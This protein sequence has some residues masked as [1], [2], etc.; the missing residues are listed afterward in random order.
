[1]G[2]LYE[3]KSASQ[4]KQSHTVGLLLHTIICC[5]SHLLLSKMHVFLYKDKHLCLVTTKSISLFIQDMRHRAEQ[6]LT[7]CACAWCTKV[8]ACHLYQLWKTQVIISPI[9]E[10]S[11]TSGNGGLCQENIKLL[12]YRGTWPLWAIL[13]QNLLEHIMQGGS[14]SAGSLPLAL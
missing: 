9:A 10:C 13:L 8:F 5:I 4:E 6:P 2:H 12:G 14:C 1:M 7:L 11:I 3:T